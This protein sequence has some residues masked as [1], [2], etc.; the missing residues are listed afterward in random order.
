MVKTRQGVKGHGIESS[1][2]HRTLCKH[3]RFPLQ[4]GEDLEFLP[5]MLHP[6][7]PDHLTEH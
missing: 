5:R 4:C 7:C 2:E 6:G 3:E 1:Q